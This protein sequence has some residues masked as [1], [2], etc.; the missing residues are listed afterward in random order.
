MSLSDRIRPNSE[1]APWV[2]KEVKK[3]EAKLAAYEQEHRSIHTVTL[4]PHHEDMK[5]IPLARCIGFYRDREAARNGLHSRGDTEAG[6][7][8]YAIL[9]RYEEGAWAMSEEPEW[10][11][12]D[13]FKNEWIQVPEPKF[14]EYTV[15]YGIG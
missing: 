12:Y 2:I 15:N 14:A 10:Y 3:M 13:F 4:V 8:N 1:A 9:E 7:Y 6:Y 11:Q 5:N